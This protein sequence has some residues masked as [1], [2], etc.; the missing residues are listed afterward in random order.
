VDVDALTHRPIALAFVGVMVADGPKENNAAFSQAGQFFQERLLLSLAR[1]GLRA[2]GVYAQRPVASYPADPTLWFSGATATVAQKFRIVLLPFINF[3]PLKTFSVAV[4]LFVALLRWGWRHRKSR[5]RVILLYNLA[6]PPGI[7]SVVAGRLVGASV[8]AVVADIQIP[9]SGMV[10]DTFFR[11]VEHR[12]Q[13]A[14]MRRCDGLVVL[15]RA[16]AL[17]FAPG[18]PYLR[19]EGAVPDALDGG[20]LQI[21][22][23]KV[24][25]GR[26]GDIVIM[27]A[28]GL[29]ELK[30]IP[31]L[32]RAMAIL[33]GE[34]YRLWIT[35][36]GPL[37][38]MVE[39]ASRADDRIKYWGYA[40]YAEVARLMQRA[41][42]LVNP[43]SGHH[44]SSRYLF[45]SKLI[46]YLATGTPVITTGSTPEVQEEYAG[47]AFVLPD[48]DPSTLAVTVQRVAAM[49]PSELASLG[50]RA[51]E[52]VFA[53]KSWSTQG[54]RIADFIRTVLPDPALR[55]TGRAL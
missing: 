40:P 20:T 26:D 8:V 33:P 6:A 25:C 12:L 28:G 4:G 14:A 23:T 31:L 43:H 53:H 41:T 45:P 7:V 16:M 13:A 2:D 32:L 36:D 17:D 39:E 19:M 22:D 37:R 55:D 21:A 50:A 9:G 38:R 27:Y 51:Q 24:Q 18:V 49:T 30:G 10:E 15:T 1:H 11:R 48:E 44:T 3:G 34:Q 46:E 29:S 42:V 5:E 52:Y 47:V 35:G 54:S